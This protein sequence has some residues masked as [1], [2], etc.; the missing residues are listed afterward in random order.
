[1]SAAATGAWG[2][3]ME[4]FARERAQGWV[5][6]ARGAS[7]PASLWLRFQGHAYIRS[8]QVQRCL[9]RHHIDELFIHR[10]DNPPARLGSA[11][12]PLYRVST[13]HHQAG[14]PGGG[15]SPQPRDSFLRDNLK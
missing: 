3:E 5:N 13:T 9:T 10:K 2:R 14:Q 4:L 12:A 7:T 11:K 15:A 1:M 8:V 6:H